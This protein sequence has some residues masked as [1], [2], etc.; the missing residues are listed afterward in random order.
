MPGTEKDRKPGFW[1]QRATK[2]NIVPWESSPSEFGETTG[3][4]I[5]LRGLHPG[6]C[7][8]CVRD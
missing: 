5:R 1:K 6:F 7:H 2:I 8:G 3:Q 4:G